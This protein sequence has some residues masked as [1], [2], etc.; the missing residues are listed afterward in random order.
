MG[1]FTV[2]YYSM[3]STYDLNNEDY[4]VTLMVKRKGGT[5][6]KISFPND[7]TNLSSEYEIVGTS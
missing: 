5:V 2:V 3:T 1:V 6:R 4:S 7:C